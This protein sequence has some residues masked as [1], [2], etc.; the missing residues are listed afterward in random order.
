MKINVVTKDTVI[1]EN[2]YYYSGR[3]KKYIVFILEV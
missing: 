2:K 3:S 1:E